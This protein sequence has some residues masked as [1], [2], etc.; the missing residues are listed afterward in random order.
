MKRYL[1]VLC[2]LA[3]MF[4]LFSCGNLPR[5]ASAPQVSPS[6][7]EVPV[8][9]Y[10]DTELDRA[11][12]LGIGVYEEP[13]QAVTYK[14]FFQ[15]PGSRRRFG[16]QRSTSRLARAVVRSARFKR[17]N[18]PFGRYDGGFEMRADLR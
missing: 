17:G 16:R 8:V 18:D 2:V 3:L 14:Q 10:G 12:S 11:V 1:S 7:T 4:N 5:E 15:M 13:N 9:L 6:I